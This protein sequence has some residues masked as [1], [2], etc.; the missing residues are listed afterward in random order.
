MSSSETEETES[1]IECRV[2][3]A[4]RLVTEQLHPNFLNLIQEKGVPKV[5]AEMSLFKT[6]TNRSTSIVDGW[7]VRVWIKDPENRNKKLRESIYWICL[8]V[9]DKAST[10][11]S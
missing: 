5:G 8:H 7:G 6:S 4:K 10:R 2:E 9:C 1:T 3:E 11:G